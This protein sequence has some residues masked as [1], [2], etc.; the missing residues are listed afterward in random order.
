MPLRVGCNG[1]SGFTMAYKGGRQQQLR[2]LARLIN[3]EIRATR[4]LVNAISAATSR[5]QSTKFANQ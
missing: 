1:A 2:E 4:D 5:Q 3:A